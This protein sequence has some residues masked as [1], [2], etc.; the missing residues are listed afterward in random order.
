MMEKLKKSSWLL[1]FLLLFP[2]VVLADNP[3]CTLNLAKGGKNTLI[4]GDTVTINLGVDEA[5]S[6]MLIYEL[7]YTISYDSTLFELV[8][9]NNHYVV[10]I[11]GWSIV[12]ESLD[13]NNTLHT[14]DFSIATTNE[15]KMVKT[16][17]TI[18]VNALASLKLRLRSTQSSLLGS[19]SDTNIVLLNSSKYK[20]Y[21]ETVSEDNKKEKIC[22]RSTLTLYVKSDVNTL[23]SIKVNNQNVEGFSENVSIYHMTVNGSIEQVNIET[24]KKDSKSVVSGDIG[25]K[26]IDYGV[27]TF[28]INVKSESGVENIYT[29]YITRQDNRSSINTLKSLKLSKGELYFDPYFDDYVVNVEN[30]VSKIE[31]TSE[32]TD[33]KSK[34]LVDYSKKEVNILEGN[35]RISITVIAENGQ[36]RT[37]TITI[38]RKLSGNNILK[39]LTINGTEIALSESDFAYTYTVENSVET[40]DIKAVALDSKA[41]IEIEK[42]NNL[43]VGENEIG[44]FVTA[45]NGD[46]VRYTLYINRKNLLS[47]DSLIKDIQIDIRNTF[48]NEDFEIKM[49]ESLT[50]KVEPDDENAII[51]IEGNSNLINGSVIKIKVTAEDGSVSRY[52]INIEKTVRG[53][54]LWLILL[55][56]FIIIFATVFIIVLMKQND[57]K[58]EHMLGK[59]SNSDSEKEND[60]NTI[61]KPLENREIE[62]KTENN[63]ELVKKEHK[64]NKN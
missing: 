35:N 52:F 43:S 36:E 33:A 39:Q 12:S 61:D 29:L 51:E 44:I 23:S 31:I 53:S 55:L 59:N 34:Y 64:E 3:N 4:K 26:K 14:L 40:V 54:W 15:N 24:V 60:L 49:E 42:S 2:I 9:T 50:I 25:T 8:L 20:H 41:K 57:R 56:I 17:N 37:Y 10:P 58:K 48:N 47:N 63:I 5:S 32:L 28:K 45:P 30:E 46:V 11:D 6:N 38:N 62:G 1:V 19:N 7:N 21:L 16:G 13:T 27:N 18:N 22:N